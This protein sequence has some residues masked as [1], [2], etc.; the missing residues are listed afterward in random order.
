[1]PTGLLRQRLSPVRQTFGKHSGELPEKGGN[2]KQL[3][4][5][6]KRLFVKVSKQGEREKR[7]KE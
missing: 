2:Q 6:V 3:F 4:Q 1:M 7:N 5:L